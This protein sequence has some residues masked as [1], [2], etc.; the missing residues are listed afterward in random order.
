MSSTMTL[1][2]KEATRYFRYFA[3]LHLLIWTFLPWLVSP[4]APLD[5]IEGYAWGQEFLLGTYKHPP[6]QAWWLEILATLTGHAGFAH[7]FASQIA[8]L[9]TFWAIWDIAKKMV[10]PASAL[11]AVILLEAIPYYN[12]TTPE[13]NPNVLLICFWAL[14]ARSFY[15]AVITGHTRHWVLFGLWA[16]CGMYS[17]YFTAIILFVLIVF[18]F[19]HPISRKRLTTFGPYLSIIVCLALC[20]PHLVWLVQ[21]DFLPITYTQS[22]LADGATREFFLNQSGKFVLTQFAI[23]LPMLLISLFLRAKNPS[24][25]DNTAVTT[26]S[27]DRWFLH[28]MTFGPLIVT[29]GISMVLHAKLKDMWGMPF[30]NFI[31]LWLI[32]VL[33]KTAPAIKKSF[34][35]AWTIWVSAIAILFA[36]VT[37]GQPYFKSGFKRVHFPGYQLASIVDQHW[38][39]QYHTPLPYVIGE[40]WV[41]GNIAYYSPAHP[42]AFTD[43]NPHISHWIDVNDVQRRGGVFVAWHCF[44]GACSEEASQK[45]A[46]DFADHVKAAYPNA[47]LQTPLSLKPQTASSKT[48]PVIIDW[49]IIPPQEKP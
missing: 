6:M 46:E 31:G 7:Y 11:V 15:L 34:V 27:F 38:Q 5:V 16:A 25:E 17:K 2:D 49:A 26:T 35:I 1:A 36:V 37:F 3:L 8:I 45:E 39:N 22:R 28:A 42:T 10:S 44:S 20:A 30:W 12:F 43:N 18:T 9:I 24:A 19:I 47:Q 23:L 4:N 48:A 41:A 40:T 29:C 13:F 33:Y 32:I 21:H 14:I